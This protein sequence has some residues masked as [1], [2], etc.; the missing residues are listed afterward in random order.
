VPIH[1][2]KK[3]TVLLD[4]FYSSETLLAHDAAKA[5]CKVINGREWLLHQG[6]AAFKLFTGKTAPQEAMRRALQGA[7]SANGKKNI[8]LIG[9]MGSGKSTAAVLLGKKCGM[10]A[11]ET[12]TSW[13]AWQA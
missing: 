11:L 1:L 9:F 4:A 7:A 12:T 5:G 6:A 3:G 8:A 13:S 2:L 10:P